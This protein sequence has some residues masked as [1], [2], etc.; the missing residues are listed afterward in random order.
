[1]NNVNS[2]VNKYYKSVDGVNFIML[3]EASHKNRLQVRIE[4]R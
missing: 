2:F 1:M 3:G 4:K